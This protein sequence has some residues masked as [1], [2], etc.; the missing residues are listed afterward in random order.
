LRTLQRLAEEPDRGH[1]LQR[2][3]DVHQHADAGQIEAL[4]GG[5][6][7]QQRQGGER[8]RAPHQQ[9][10]GRRIVAGEH[11]MAALCLPQAYSAHTGSMARVSSQRPETASTGNCLRTRP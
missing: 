11:R 6:K 4:R 5:G 7:S 3:V 9:G 10:R 1:E 2:R 8:T